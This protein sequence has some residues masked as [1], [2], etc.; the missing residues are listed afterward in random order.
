[1]H[2]G[3]AVLKIFQAIARRFKVSE[4]VAAYRLL[5]LGFI[6]QNKFNV[7]YHEYLNSEH[8]NSNSIQNGG[9]FYA[10]QNVRISRHFGMAV[11]CAT[12]GGNLLYRD[13]YNLTGLHGET[14]ESYAESIG[15]R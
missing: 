15:M 7:F 1:M 8:R 11:I 10:T 3:R 4:I 9:D 13:A 6:D 12:R 5:N 2:L 14:F